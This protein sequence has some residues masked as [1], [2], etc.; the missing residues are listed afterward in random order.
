MA[1]IKDIDA[2]REF[3]KEVKRTFAGGIAT[4]HTYR[5]VLKIL[6]DRLGAGEVYA[7][8]EPKRIAC[9]APDLALM[10]KDITVGYLEAKNIN[11]SI[12]DLKDANKNQFERYTQNLD[13]LI[14][15]N[16]LDW[17]FYRDGVLV[18][19]VSIAKIESGKIIPNPDSFADL[20][21]FLQNLM[22]QPPQTI[23]RADELAKYMAKRTKMIRDSFQLDME[24][25]D[26][27]E[28][29]IAQRDW[30]DEVLVKDI[31]TEKFASMYAQT[32]TYGMFVAKL[33]NEIYNKKPKEFI[34]QNIPNL[35]PE[36]HP[37]LKNLFK[38]IAEG[39]LN[40]AINGFINDL[41]NLY[42]PAKIKDIMDTY[43]QGSERK[44]PFIHFYEDFLAAYNPAERELSG[45]YY[46]PKPVVNFIVR[47][48]DWVL[49]NK[50][51][52]AD[53]LAHS[54]KTKV[55]W[56]TDKVGELK[57]VNVHK[58]QILDP[59]TGTGTF[60]AQ[61]IRHI[62]QSKK[63]TGSA[64]WS[65]YVDKDLLPRLHGFEF[66]MA[67]YAMSYLKLD[68]VLAELKYKQ[69]KDHPKRISI[70]LTNSLTGANKDI[71]HLPFAK[72]LEDEAKGATNIKDNFPIM[73][74]IGNPPYNAKSENDDKWIMDLMDAY[75]KE[76]GGH[77]PLK[78]RNP[79][80]IN[81]DYVKFI[82]MAEYMVHKNG[83]GVVGM[84]TN[85]GY[86]D[87][88]TFRG[89]RWHLMNSFDEIYVLNLHGSIDENRATSKGKTDKNV[90]DIKTGV[91][92]IIAW[93]KKQINKKKSL[94]HVFRA[95]LWGAREEKFKALSTEGL[96]SKLFQK[97]EPRKPDYFFKTVDYKLK[98]EYDKGFKITK[99]FDTNAN[100]MEGADDLKS[101]KTGPKDRKKI[102][103][104]SVGIVT[105]GDDFIIAENIEKLRH[106][107]ND[108]LKTDKSEKDIQRDYGVTKNY[109]KRLL[110]RKPKLKIDDG[111][112]KPIAYRPFDTRIVYFDN[113]LIDRSRK[114]IMD[115]FLI[116]NNF[117]LIAKR[118]L[119]Q[120]QSAPVFCTNTISD[121]RYWSTSG[122]QGGDYVFPLYFQPNG[123]KDL[124]TNGH[125]K[126]VNMDETIRKAIEDSATDSKHK[127]PDEKEIFDYIYGILHAPKYR[128]RYGEFLKSDFPYVP[129]PQT[130]AEFWH[131]S[132]VGTK[133]REMHL[134][135]DS[136]DGS[137]YTFEGDDTTPIVE[138]PL[139]N[140]GKVWINDSQYF[141]NVPESAWNFYI[142]GYQPAQKWLKDRKGQE[143][144]Y[145]DYQKIIAVLV[146]TQT[147]M[148]D[149]KWSRP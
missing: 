17:D 53:G 96:D 129:Y 89:M 45:V 13:N 70:Y 2:I 86:L 21:K 52:L 37:F 104:H 133:L 149:I 59:A 82:R 142:G 127:K 78:E 31:T 140:N 92:I 81:D 22:L 110:S 60:L 40:P 143:I 105:G 9:G 136:L 56:K 141:A 130:P 109:A 32:I 10:R 98:A 93:K 12:R 41:I 90:F 55:K 145:E 49:K 24:G 54:K 135:P 102:H 120:E 25:D 72:Y 48:V 61:T 116:G 118:G 30:I 26:P 23:K 84:I 64:G 107:L 11:I 121:F 36:T 117:G 131:L 95:D 34:R 144:D 4:E 16:C 113:L 91:S 139:F 5:P 126:K 33:Y 122:M 57:N 77:A 108:F 18:H 137:A 73:C 63:K 99:L 1:D 28:N 123:N 46:T 47:G 58:V 128:E 6:L 7:V 74:V 101:Q 27:S 75:K 66:M 42:R 71:P 68:M 43:G 35:L 114:N 19:N 103:T 38:F 80:S 138:R 69:T 51:N 146:Q 8:N 97:L 94:A 115:H 39:T 20:I 87:N 125:S 44:D 88:L 62:A 134:K 112:F 119:I 15:T 85:H 106:R 111:E 3:M 29:L 124:D 79:K 65:S 50:F 147:T 76:P 132:S 148:D 100:M 67:P 14:Y 83:D